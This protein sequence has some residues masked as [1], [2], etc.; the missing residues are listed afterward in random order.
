MCL[1]CQECGD[2]RPHGVSYPRRASCTSRGPGMGPGASFDPRPLPQASKAMTR[3]KQ[4]QV[5]VRPRRQPGLD[6]CSLLLDDVQQ[7]GPG[8]CLG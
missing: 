8:W 5:E 4:Q 6:V 7:Q 3:P 2:T 1:A